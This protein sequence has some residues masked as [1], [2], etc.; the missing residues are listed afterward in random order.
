MAD[1][2]CIWYFCCPMKRYRERG[3]IDPSWVE[4]YCHGMWEE[5]VRFQKVKAGEPHPDWMLPDG[6]LDESLAGPR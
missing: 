1:G 6:T 3:L 5:C 2:T 4:R